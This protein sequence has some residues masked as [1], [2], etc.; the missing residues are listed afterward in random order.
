VIPPLGALAMLACHGQRVHDVQVRIDT[1][2]QE[3]ATLQAEAGAMRAA[4]D[5]IPPPTAAVRVDND[6][7]GFDAD[8]PLPAGH[9]TRPDV[10][11]LSIDTLRA[12]HLGTYGYE[13]PTSPTFDALA[14]GGTVFEQ[15]WSPSSWTL[16][17]HTTMLS[18]I[19]PVHH[20]TIDD[21]L[22]IADDV[23]LLGEAF[24]GAG[25]ATQAVVST[26][27]VS[28]RFGFDRGF[29]R[30]EDFGIRSK[31]KNNLSTVDADHVFH[32]ALHHAQQVPE[33]TPMFLFLH[34]YDVHYGYDA[35][36]PYNERFDRRPAWGD[37]PYKNYFAYKQRM[38][39]RDQLEH[40]IAQYDEEI[41]YVDAMFDALLQRW[42]A[43]GRE[44]IVVVT[45]DH[46][47]EFGERD[48]WGHAHTLW[49]EQLHV[50]LIVSGPGIRPQRVA[51]RVGIEDIAPTLA[52]LAGVWMPARDGVSRAAV[53]RTGVDE[54]APDH[55]SGR[56]ADT[57]RFDTLVYRWHDGLYDL[58]VDLRAGHRALCK[59]DEDPGCAI[60]V[61]RRHKDQADQMF[62]D[63][64]HFLGEPWATRASGRVS[65]DGVLFVD[66]Q[67]VKGP[68][69]RML[70]D[71]TFAVH[72]ADA[73]VR[74]TADEGA[75]ILGP[76]QPLGGAIPGERCPIAYTGRFTV[77]TELPELSSE[78]TAMLESLGYLQGDENEEPG[79]PEAPS[80]RV[81]CP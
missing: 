2:K 71:K 68:A 24:Q 55:V 22:R 39:D 45:A 15:A 76:W 53:L 41:L 8:R 79:S 58:H 11:L 66:G 37:E 12:D 52:E 3:V 6:P 72:P 56:F 40:Q 64:T 42:R 57:S 7:P 49:P 23:P 38:V 80:G 74:W 19:L 47:E 54:T 44:A 35:P 18:G 63:L 31:E 59:L 48:S 33:G 28:S 51:T 50:P 30:F 60:N 9:P 1:L 34:V 77:G 5:A 26:L 65:T 21:H 69:A 16:P 10:I 81:D 46:G 67:R 14:A 43:A 29:D 32:Y 75:T 13:R 78:D 73:F 27:F 36:P 20:G 4:L 17:S 70:P 61:Y 62:A 25:Y